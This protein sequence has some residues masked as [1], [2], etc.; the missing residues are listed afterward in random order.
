M[1]HTNV[2]KYIIQKTHEKSMKCPYLAYFIFDT[3]N[4]NFTLDQLKIKKKYTERNLYIAYYRLGK[5]FSQ[6]WYR[7]KTFAQKAIDV[8]SHFFVAPAGGMQLIISADILEY[9]SEFWI[10]L[11]TLISVWWGADY[12]YCPLSV[13]TTW[14]H[15]IIRQQWDA[16]VFTQLT[17]N[18]P[19]I[20]TS[21]QQWWLATQTHHS[22]TQNTGFQ[23]RY[24]DSSVSST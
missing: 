9:S 23:S 4:I 3:A 18:N 7:R 5:P 20:N 14:V 21:C 19:S 8:F 16:P 15:L 22:P 24:H 2:T 10:F 1:S 17:R 12:T 13:F 6:D 11:Q